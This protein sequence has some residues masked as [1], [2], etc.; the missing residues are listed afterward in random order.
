MIKP[1]HDY[2]VVE[3]H[4]VPH[5]VIEWLFENYGIGDGTRW[6]YKHPKIFFANSKDHM[7]FLLRWG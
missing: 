4:K 3:M 5:Y 2:Y 1:N 6:I 7:M